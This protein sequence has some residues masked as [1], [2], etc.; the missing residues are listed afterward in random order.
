MPEAR[1][2]KK[3]P[4]RRLY[5]TEESRYI[6]L[7]DIRDLV[8]DQ[9]D[10]VVIDKKSGD[11]ITRSILLQV[12]SEQEANGEAVMSEDFLSQIIRSYGNV[13]PGFMTS[14]LEQSMQTMM[15]Q[16]KLLRGQM[17]RVVGVDPV[18]VV[19]E[20]T[21]QNLARFQSLQDEILSRFA[22]GSDEGEEPAFLCCSFADTS[23]GSSPSSL[24]RAKRLRIS[25]CND[26]KRARF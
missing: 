15:R 2:I 23:A 3:Y 16:Q 1:V 12:I 17:K 21:Q 22:R 4:N 19:A 26:W 14:Y 7:S 25:S 5:D 24:P 8:V 18:T 13:M 20:L 6:T 9:V 11:D 10:F